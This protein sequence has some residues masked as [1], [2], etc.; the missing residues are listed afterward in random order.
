MNNIASTILSVIQLVILLGV[1]AYIILKLVKT[2]KP[3]IK[4]PDFIRLIIDA[5]A[6]AETDLG[7]GKGK[8]KLQ[9]VVNTALDYCEQNGV[10][11]TQEQLTKI[12]NL[13]VSIA[14]LIKKFIAK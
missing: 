9:Y 6:D 1:L 12:V 3:I 14:N 2:F 13:I 10:N 5:I 7:A 11:F 4:N 8:E